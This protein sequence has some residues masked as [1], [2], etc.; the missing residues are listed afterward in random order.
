MHLTD[1]GT[2]GLSA[3]PERSPGTG[4]RERVGVG[5]GGAV[6]DEVGREGREGGGGFCRE[7]GGGG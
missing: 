2:N 5:R 4:E 6:T 1:R 7:R 3:T